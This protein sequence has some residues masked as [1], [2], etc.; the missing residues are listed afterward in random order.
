MSIATQE[1]PDKASPP[2]KIRRQRGARIESGNPANRRDAAMARLNERRAHLIRMAQRKVIRLALAGKTVSADDLRNIEVGDVE[3][4]F[5]GAVFRTLNAAGVLQAAGYRATAVPG[6]HA[7]PI[8]AW[9]LRDRQT[10]E[11]WLA[12]HP[13][14]DPLAAPVQ[15]RLDLGDA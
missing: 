5:V 10:A 13:D 14:P 7:R 15:K 9:H 8:L 2:L 12:D 4:H 6:S 1:T 11:R 3:R